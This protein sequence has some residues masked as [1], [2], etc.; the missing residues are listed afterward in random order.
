[1][2]GRPAVGFGGGGVRRSLPWSGIDQN[3]PCRTGAAGLAARRS[4]SGV[5]GPGSLRAVQTLGRLERDEVPWRPST[6]RRNGGNGLSMAVGAVP[7]PRRR[8]PGPSPAPWFEEVAGRRRA[9]GGG[10]P[11]SGGQRA[12]SLQGGRRSGNVRSWPQRKAARRQRGRT[13]EMAASRFL[14]AVESPGVLGQ[15]RPRA[16]EEVRCPAR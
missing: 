8:S 11:S 6:G 14:R 16:P 5:C 4:R 3:R 9:E 1:M 7:Q 15:P 10:G 12:S 2:G 13:A